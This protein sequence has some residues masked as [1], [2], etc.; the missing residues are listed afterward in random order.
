[1]VQFWYPAGRYHGKLSSYR[2][3]A[4][5]SARDARFSLV[6]THSIVDAPLAPSRE[7]FPVVLYAPSWDGIR[8]EN[9]SQVEE[10]ASQGYVVVGIDHPHS[11]LA[12][13]FPD[14]RIVRTKLVN[15][16][17]FSSDS[18]FSAFMKIAETQVRIRSDDAS[19]LLDALQDIDAADPQ[20]FFTGRL[21]LGHVGIFGFSLG[22]GVAAQTCWRDRRFKA[23]VN[24]DGMMAG[25]SL[26]HGALAPYLIMSEGDPVSPEGISDI[27]PSRRRELTL[28]WEQF[29]QMRK[30]FS[31]FGGYWLTIGRAKHANF[32]DFAFSSPLRTYSRSGPIIPANATRIINQYMCAF[33]DRYLRGVD[34]PIFDERYPH[35]REVRFERLEFDRR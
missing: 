26:E 23:C 31:S 30:L 16:N 1:M 20:N 8:T 2:E 15:E 10:L 28:D 9:T 17:A 29:A 34:V 21:D 33:F 11:S 4:T 27:S 24:L 25:E 3:R 18:T 7:R 6:K 22:G 13:V 14:G 12:T 35:D 19:F 32:S 5:T